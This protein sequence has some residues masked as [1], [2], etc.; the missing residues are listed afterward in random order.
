[1]FCM[2]C[3]TE[4]RETD[5]YCRSCG[6]ALSPAAASPEPVAA[7]PSEPKA[8][9]AYAQGG[10]QGYAQSG[11]PGYQPQSYAQPGYQPP[12]NYGTYQPV[13]V[14]E[15]VLGAAWRDITSTAGW[16]KKVILLCLLGCVPILN[17][18]VEGF[19]L[20]WSRDLTLGNREPMPKEV[21]KK[22]EILT[23]FRAWI[24]RIAYDFIY[25]FLSFLAVVLLAALFGVFSAEAAA[26][27]SMLAIFLL[28]LAYAFF[29]YPVENAAIIRMVTVDYIEGGLNIQKI[30]QAFRR[31]M[32][33]A[34]AGSVVPPL[35]VGIIQG[36]LLG[37]LTAIMTAVATS[38][39]GG[40]YDM[41]YYAPYELGY[42]S[43]FANTLT[44]LG[45]G[46]VFLYAV[47]CL[48]NAMLSVFAM[49]IRWR[50]LGHW[51]ART[52]PEWKDES[53][54]ETI[55]SMA[56][57]RIAQDSSGVPL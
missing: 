42:M 35:A 30:W 8:A 9:P 1:M 7:A 4:N 29:Y 10:L 44:G 5:A 15:G 55:A 43:D 26:G 33:S 56:A 13:S 41:Y 39:F 34:I 14:P 40:Y 57:D 2:Q 11:Q 49:L 45:A 28:V 54:E 38:T 20:R 51:A 17:F 24:L 6:S 19:A 12:Q 32:G 31:S 48:V 25:L 52:A 46:F 37:L 21:F 16:L 36:I 47:I 18:G 22:K 53:D 50:A 27:I 3:G 23:G